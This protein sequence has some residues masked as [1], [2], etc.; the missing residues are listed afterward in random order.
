MQQQR[1]QPDGA[2]PTGEPPAAEESVDLEALVAAVER[3]L[4]RDLEV[5]RERLGLG[6]RRF[7]RSDR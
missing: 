2:R 3:L 6:A 5:A 4:R 1:E 7:P